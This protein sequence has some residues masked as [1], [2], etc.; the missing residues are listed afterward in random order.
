MRMVCKLAREV[1]VGYCGGPSV[2]EEEAVTVMRRVGVRHDR[3]LAKGSAP[4]G[5][6][7]SINLSAVN[8]LP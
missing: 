2:C 3:S 8:I 5:L 6:S 7:G 1:G 4:R